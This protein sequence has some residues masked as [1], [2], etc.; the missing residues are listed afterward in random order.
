MGTGAPGWPTERVSSSTARGSNREARVAAGTREA[1]RVA[2]GV[3]ARSGSRV[4]ARMVAREVARVVAREVARVVAREVASPEEVGREVASPSRAVTRARRACAGT[5]KPVGGS[6]AILCT[7][8]CRIF[9]I[10][11]TQETL[12]FGET[13]GGFS[14]RGRGKTG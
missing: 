13:M 9:R 14:T 11:R 1:V 7:Q 2:A 10:Y 3:A 6:T 12:V 8:A 5:T 4:V